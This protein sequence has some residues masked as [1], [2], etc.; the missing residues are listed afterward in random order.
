MVKARARHILVSTEEACNN[1]K[2]QIENNIH[3]YPSVIDL[4]H[5]LKL[6]GANHVGANQRFGLLGKQKLEK[7]K[8]VYEPHR[9][10]QGLIPATF[11]IIYGC[12][13]L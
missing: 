4:M 13:A 11:E 5:K 10:K 2:T 1:L 6:L 8:L 12:V 7:L 3:T 9:N